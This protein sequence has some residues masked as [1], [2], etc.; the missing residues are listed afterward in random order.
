LPSGL[1]TYVVSD[2]GATE[3]APE[4]AWFGAFDVIQVCGRVDP[5][6]VR[7]FRAASLAPVVFTSRSNAKALDRLG[8]RPPALERNSK[9]DSLVGLANAVVACSNAE[10]EEL[11]LDYPQFAEKISFIHNALDPGLLSAIGRVDV[12]SRGT[13]EPAF[14]FVGRLRTHKGILDLLNVCEGLWQ[15]GLAFRFK[16]AGGHTHQGES[17]VQSLLARTLRL[18]PNWLEMHKWSD[19]PAQVASVYR[20]VHCVISPSRYEPF[21]LVAVEALAAGCYVIASDAG[22]LRETLTGLSCATTYVRG[23]E[24]ALRHEVRRFVLGPL[25]TVMDTQRCEHWIRSRFAADRMAARYLELYSKLI[26]D[27]SSKCGL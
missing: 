2:A 7:N 6:L 12:G 1:K 8:T 4:V 13:T 16:I 15:E 19:D 22:G 18:W 25:W 20:S 27:I 24:D 17:V 5:V 11:R 26:G 14:A 9:Q 10:A 23:D 3:V 21:G